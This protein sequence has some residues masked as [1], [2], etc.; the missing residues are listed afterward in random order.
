M[1]GVKTWLS[2]QA[3][4]VFDTNVQIRIPVTTNGSIPA[5]TTL[6]GGLSMDVFLYLMFF[7]LV[8]LTAYRKLLF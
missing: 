7:L 2:S 1:D 5:M 4:Q 8:L 6:R 3:A